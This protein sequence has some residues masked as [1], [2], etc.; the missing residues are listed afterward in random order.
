VQADYVFSLSLVALVCTGLGC[1][2]S[3]GSSPTAP[4]SVAAP[5]TPAARTIKNASV[6]ATPAGDLQIG[7]IESTTLT[8]TVDYSDGSTSS[9]PATC[10]PE[11]NSIYTVTAD[12]IVTAVGEGSETV[13][14]SGPTGI[15]LFTITVF[16]K[17]CT[18]AGWL[19]GLDGSGGVT[20][21]EEWV[22]NATVRI[23]SA[24][25]T[26][27][28]AVG[29]FKLEV[30][31]SGRLP[32]VIEA[33]GYY[34]SE[35][36][37]DVS[38]SKRSLINGVHAVHALRDLLPS[39]KLNY[40]DLNFYDHILRGK[41][42][43]GAGRWARVPT[44]EIWTQQM[45]CLESSDGGKGCEKYKVTAV[46]TPSQFEITSRSVV[47]NDFPRLTGDVLTGLNITT[48]NQTAGTTL[49][50]SGCSEPDKIRVLYITPGSSSYGNSYSAAKWC[51]YQTSGDIRGVEIH[52]NTA[53]LN[54]TGVYQHEFAHGL[55]WDHPDSYAA[56]PG[57]S[58]MKNNI[59]SLGD[60]YAGEVLYKLRPAGSLSP[61]KD[62]SGN[63]MNYPEEYRT[64]VF[65][66]DAPG[67]SLAPE[68]VPVNM[69][70]TLLTDVSA[71]PMGQ[72][73]SRGPLIERRVY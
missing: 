53:H 47:N 51:L 22:G 28:D 2:S 54:L 29:Y 73:W 16:P 65:D 66:F 7:G 70:P 55:G 20:R 1:G 34:R 69:A 9:I 46:D 5:T 61:D 12:C 35:S 67:I 56:V 13:S 6:S 38:L 63:T 60:I 17:C 30:D 23:G 19:R 37:L 58:V 27:T 71:V 44:V 31:E 68:M 14:V 39:N 40:F 3:G 25:S 32:V 24:A 36:Q 64:L 18:V 42:A 41:G 49:Q 62:P 57:S 11:S 4:T 59:V 50:W 48:K 43:R 10:T 21:I 45:E 52:M 33:S 8:L 72:V 15:L 26:T